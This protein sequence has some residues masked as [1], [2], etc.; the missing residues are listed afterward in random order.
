MA[1][2]KREVFVWKTKHEQFFVRELLFVEP[3]S[4]KHGSK[5]RGQAWTTVADN[6]NS[7]DRPKFKVTQRSVREKFEK[8]IQNFRKNEAYEQ[9]ASG[10]DAEHDE[11]SQALTEINEKINE[12]DRLW[13]EEKARTTQKAELEASQATEIR[14]KATER[15]G[16][17]RERLGQQKEN[18]KRRSSTDALE[19]IQE[20]LKTKKQQ[21]ERELDLR[22]QELDERRRQAEETRNCQQMQMQWMQQLQ[23]QQQQIMETQQQHN[24]QMMMGMMEL[25]KNINK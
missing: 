17:T 11:V 15:L 5:E 7:S 12:Y 9:R 25:I 18:K 8:M 24:M 22:T 6:L 4:F 10:I 20:S 21:V 16:Q 3:F 14:R 1:T 2:P 13:S 19:I 23:Q